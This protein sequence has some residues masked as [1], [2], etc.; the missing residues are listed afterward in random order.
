MRDLSLLED[1]IM[2]GYLGLVVIWVTH[3]L[4]PL[5]V[6]RSCRVSVMVAELVTTLSEILEFYIINF[7]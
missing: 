5:R 4:W 7:Y 3:P 6:P 1:R 2:S